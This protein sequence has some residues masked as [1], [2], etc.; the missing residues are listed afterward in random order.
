MYLYLYTLVA[1]AFLA[2]HSFAFLLYYSIFEGN[3]VSW[4]AHKTAQV[5]ADMWNER[6]GQ[7]GGSNSQVE[8]GKGTSGEGQGVRG[9]E[10][11]R[12]HWHPVSAM[13]KQ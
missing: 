6:P 3:I 12:V 9:G 11:V 5:P 10:C 4:V 8:L 13:S 1:L 2:L 7:G